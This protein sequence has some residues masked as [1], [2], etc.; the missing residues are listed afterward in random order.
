MGRYSVG[1]G[2]RSG[3]SM[4]VQRSSLFDRRGIEA[5]RWA[6]QVSRSCS[7]VDVGCS[8]T[9]ADSRSLTGA[10]RKECQKKS[11]SSSDERW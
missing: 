1:P 9:T 4:V 11:V 5:S 7:Q 10:L 3:P 2:I 8:P 6:A